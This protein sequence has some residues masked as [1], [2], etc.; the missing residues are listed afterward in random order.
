MSMINNPKPDESLVACW[1][2]EGVNR[3]SVIMQII[4]AIYNSPGQQL[5]SDLS[6]GTLKKVLAELASDLDLPT[7]ELAEGNWQ[8]IQA[9]YVSLFVTNPA[10]VPAQPYVAYLLDG[11]L[12]GVKAQEL[13]RFYQQKGFMLSSAWNDLPDHLAVV[14]EAVLQL[15]EAEAVDAAMYLLSQYVVPWFKG[16]SATIEAYD[17][18]N[19]YGPIT[20]FLEK[21]LMEVTREVSS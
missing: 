20:V 2:G 11:E 18:S 14:A 10:G 3:I 5:H 15:L 12:L 4:A 17:S 1:S 9:A 7:V 13:Q 8:N 6:S 21:A 16:F 19:F